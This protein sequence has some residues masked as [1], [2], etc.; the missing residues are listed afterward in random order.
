MNGSGFLELISIHVLLVHLS[1][2]D[3][4]DYFTAGCEDDSQKSASAS[5]E[6]TKPSFAVILAKVFNDQ[7]TGPIEILDD[8]K[9]KAALQPVPFRFGRIPFGHARTPAP[10]E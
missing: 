8:F 4:A 6:S 2:A 9:A 3:D 1:N 7:S 5:P 10:L